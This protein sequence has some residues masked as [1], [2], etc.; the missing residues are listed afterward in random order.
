MQRP[1]N[2]FVLALTLCA[3]TTPEEPAE[4]PPTAAGK[5]EPAVLEIGPPTDAAA[6]RQERRQ[7]ALSI[8]EGGATAAGLPLAD[9][10]P[11]REFDP[12]RID[13]LQAEASRQRGRRIPR[14]RQA[15]ATVEGGLDRDTIRRVVRDHIMEVRYCYNP[16]LVRS[17]AGRN[18]VL[19]CAAPFL[20]REV[21]RNVAR[22]AGVHQYSRDPGDIVRADSQYLV[23]HT[24]EGGDRRLRLPAP[25]TLRDALTG[26]EVGQGRSAR[27]TLPPDSTTVW[28]MSSD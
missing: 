21:L 13:C 6:T 16:G 12:A 22:E 17:G 10:D 9:T 20:P 26:Q 5:P 7:A 14:V 2:V 3:C 28:E 15:K 23:I 24:R 1:A 11:D 25:V 4:S 19:Y 8:L 18:L 27:V